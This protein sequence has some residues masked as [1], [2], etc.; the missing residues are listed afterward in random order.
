MDTIVQWNLNGFYRHLPELQI[1]IAKFQPNF[2]CLQET[3]LTPDKG[4]NI[5]G[6]T[7]HRKDRLTEQ[8]ASGGV[9]I[10]TNDTTYAENI[11]LNTEIEAVAIK[12]FVPEPVTL[13][14]IY[15]PPEHQTSQAEIELLL[16][17][18]PKP[19]IICGDFNAHNILWGSTKNTTRG[20]IIANSLEHYILLNNGEPTHFSAKNGTFSSIDLTFCDPRLF[21]K[22]S[23]YTLPYLFSGS[24]FPIIIEHSQNQSDSNKPTK[25]KNGT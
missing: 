16:Q 3:H 11:T 24:H 10:Y 6:Y 1:L 4:G 2:I 21:L 17:Q 9:A 13:C 22:F 18:L 15:L 19:L 14:N 20:N 5:K 7:A 23:W 25:I 12:T 8:K